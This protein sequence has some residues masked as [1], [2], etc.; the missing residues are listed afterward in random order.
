MDPGSFGVGGVW[1]PGCFGLEGHVRVGPSG[2]GGAGD[3]WVL[4]GLGAQILGPLV[5]ELGCLVSL[6]WG[7]LGSFGVGEVLGVWTPGSFR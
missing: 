1:V 5:W 7:G 6:G 2:L 4:G 3:M